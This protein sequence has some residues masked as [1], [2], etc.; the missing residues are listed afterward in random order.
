[1]HAIH[2]DRPRIRFILG[3]QIKIGILVWINWDQY[4]DLFASS[5]SDGF[6]E[7]WEAGV[8]VLG[9][10]YHELRLGEFI[11]FLELSVELGYFLTKFLL[12]MVEVNMVF[13]AE[14]ERGS[15]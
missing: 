8:W 5:L 12:L 11:H 15:N 13:G 9:G 7:S 6:H 14:D 3:W 4:L 10:V 2:V 1:M